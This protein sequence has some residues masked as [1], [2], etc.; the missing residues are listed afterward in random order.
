MQDLSQIQTPES[1]SDLLP[2][3]L[4][5]VPSAKAEPDPSDL[6][7]LDDLLSES[8]S[9]VVK[10]PNHRVLKETK[11]NVDDLVEMYKQIAW[12]VLE[13]ISVWQ[14]TICKCGSLGTMTF[15]RNMQKLSKVGCRKDSPQ[16]H[17]ETVAELPAGEPVRYALVEREVQRCEFCAKLE[18]EKF[19]AF[20]EVVK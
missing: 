7:D 11:R 4:L 17:W 2:E 5:A 3:S 15:V 12:D 10:A 9:L 1:L 19:E 13:N 20:G 14:M 8:M 16:L 18:I 6:T